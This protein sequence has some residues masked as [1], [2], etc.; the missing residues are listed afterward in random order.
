MKTPP[1]AIQAMAES[2]GDCYPR[3]DVRKMR[4]LIMKAIQET[5]HESARRLRNA[6][7]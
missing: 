6:S 1:Q 7:L 2:E 4:R 5:E 3:K